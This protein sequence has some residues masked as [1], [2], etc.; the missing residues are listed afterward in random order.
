[1]LRKLMSNMIREGHRLLFL[2]IEMHQHNMS[3]GTTSA[4]LPGFLLDMERTVAD[5]VDNRAYFDVMAEK[6]LVDEIQVEMRHNHRQ[7]VEMQV[8]RKNP[9]ERFAPQLKPHRY[10]QMVDVPEKINLAKLRRYC[11]Y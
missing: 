8:R 4:T 6:Y 3:P 5:F 1:M 9:V 2:E 7:V 11:P 10:G